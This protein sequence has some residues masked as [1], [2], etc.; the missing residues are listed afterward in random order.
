MRRKRE[1]VKNKMNEDICQVAFEHGAIYE[2]DENPC[3]WCG[4]VNGNFW[5][6]KL[7]KMLQPGK[8]VGIDYDPGNVNNRNNRTLHILTIVDDDYIVCKHW[9]RSK[10][11]WLYVV[12][13][14]YFFWL[15]FEPKN[16]TINLKEDKI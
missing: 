9:S 2:H 3:K 4:Q 6:K 8:K 15:H 1:K 5:T 13:H 7:R 11:S 16:I 10:Q 12:E 14:I